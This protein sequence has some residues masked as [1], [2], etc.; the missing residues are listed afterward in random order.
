M[1]H[2]KA[3]G[4]SRRGRGI[5]S[6]LHRAAPGNDVDPPYATPGQLSKGALRDVS[7]PQYVD[8]LQQDAG[9]IQGDV[10]L[11]NDNGVLATE[12]VGLEAGAFGE[13]VVPADKLAGRVD[14]R[15]GG[16]AGNAELLVLRGTVGE[17]Y[18]V[19]MAHERAKR[20]SAVV[21]GVDGL[22][23]G[24][25]AEEAEVGGRGDLAKAVLTVLRRDSGS[26]GGQREGIAGITLTSGWSGATP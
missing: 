4:W 7:L 24:D 23:D 25:V 19:V 8:I 16:L 14:A 22:T 20:H 18:G 11:A 13:T 21:G 12:E 3:P 17:K 15:Q 1:A 5:G 26:A 10:A 6:H 2:K 9:H